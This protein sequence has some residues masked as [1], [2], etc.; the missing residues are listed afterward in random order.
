MSKLSREDILKLARLS[1]LELTEEEIGH[2]QNEIGEILKYVELL[3]TVDLEG[4]E[5]TYQVTGLKDVTRK[6]EIVEYQAK[7]QDLLKNAPNS[8]ANQFKVPR[9][10]K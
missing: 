4:L 6:D 10:V 3:Q 9:M 2:F 1:R 8:E 7:P 5:P